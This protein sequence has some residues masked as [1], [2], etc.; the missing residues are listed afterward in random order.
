MESNTLGPQFLPPDIKGE[1]SP[2]EQPTERVLGAVTLDFLEP[3]AENAYRATPLPEPGQGHG[4]NSRRRALR[5]RQA[6]GE[7]EIILPPAP[8]R[9]MRL[10]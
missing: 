8:R 1:S 4:R 9:P 5:E 7:V 6:A 10:Q 2:S 3:D